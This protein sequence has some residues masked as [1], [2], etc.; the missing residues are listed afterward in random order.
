MKC[1]ESLSQLEEEPTVVFRRKHRTAPTF[2][3]SPVKKSKRTVYSVDLT[4]S[5][6][7][8]EKWNI[9]YTVHDIL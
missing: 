6:D 1:S 3:P 9:N 5:D 7:E 8:D 4:F 2:V